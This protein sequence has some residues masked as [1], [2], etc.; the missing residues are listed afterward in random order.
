MVV[1]KL[2]KLDTSKPNRR[3][4]PYIIPTRGGVARAEDILRT[5]EDEEVDDPM[6]VRRSGGVSVN[7]YETIRKAKEQ[8]LNEVIDNEKEKISSLAAKLRLN[9]QTV[10]RIWN[11]D[12]E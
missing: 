2:M 7:K 1:M 4:V 11:D 8:F 9:I 3:S 10:R 12:D 5:I 6:T